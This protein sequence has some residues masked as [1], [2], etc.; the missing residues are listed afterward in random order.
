[1]QEERRKQV[2]IGDLFIHSFVKVSDTSV[3]FAWS[4]SEYLLTLS[5]GETVDTTPV[6][7]IKRRVFRAKQALVNMAAEGVPLG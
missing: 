1:M 2:M 5:P 6:E 4:G 7:Y 3:S